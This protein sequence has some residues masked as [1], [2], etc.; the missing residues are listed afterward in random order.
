MCISELE[1]TEC[2]CVWDNTTHRTE[3]ENEFD[4]Q[5]RAWWKYLTHLRTKA[6][7]T[8]RWQPSPKDSVVSNLLSSF[9]RENVISAIAVCSNLSLHLKLLN[10]PVR[11]YDQFWTLAFRKDVDHLEKLQN[12]TR[13]ITSL[14]TWPMKKDW[15]NWTVKFVKKKSEEGSLVVSRQMTF[16]SASAGV[17]D[18][19]L[20]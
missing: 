15:R 10:L 5:V 9:S 12:T 2:A 3:I 16:L 17:A 1:D 8:F 4:K 19:A 20:G 7:M 6:N 11:F 18:P 13:K 14:K